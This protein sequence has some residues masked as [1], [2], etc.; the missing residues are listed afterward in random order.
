[1]PQV[2]EVQV[3]IGLLEVAEDQ[4][5]MGDLL[6]QEVVLEVLMLAAELVEVEALI[7][8]ELLVLLLLEVG[9]VLETTTLPMQM[10]A[11]VVLES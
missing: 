3:K 6:H 8:Q 4:L 1:M 2:Q 7:L 11:T 5:L 10:E 9:V